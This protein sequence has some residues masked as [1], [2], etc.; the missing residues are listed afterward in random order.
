MNHIKTFELAIEESRN[1]PEPVVIK[2]RTVNPGTARSRSRQVGRKSPVPFIRGPIPLRWVVK[3]ASLS[4]SAARLS[5]AIWYRLGISGQNVDLA[6]P[7]EKP[8]VV[9]VD[10]KLRT[11]CELERWHVGPGIQELRK[12]G[13]IRVLK[14]GRGRCPEIEVIL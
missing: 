2:A 3:A 10:R 7:Q 11:E 8:L 13:L 5:V 1:N 12:V 6:G 4:Q 14:A 9:R